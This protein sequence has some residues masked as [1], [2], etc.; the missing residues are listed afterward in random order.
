[1]HVATRR[2]HLPRTH[3][4]TYVRTYVA[5]YCGHAVRGR[6]PLVLR[7]CRCGKVA[8]APRELLRPG[9]N[10]K[11]NPKPQTFTARPK[12]L[13]SPAFVAAPPRP[14]TCPASHWIAQRAGQKKQSSFYG[15]EGRGIGGVG[16]SPL[17]DSL[18][19]KGKFHRTRRR[20]QIVTPMWSH[21]APPS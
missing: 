4:R 17:A 14:S 18:F 2:L 3:V 13:P 12:P 1:M 11:N 10:G 21:E 8:A 19:S 16:E 15:L 9:R 6:E 7:S 5:L 20:P